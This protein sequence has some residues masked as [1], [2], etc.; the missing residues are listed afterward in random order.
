MKAISFLLVLAA[1]TVS[2]CAPTNLG[3][4]QRNGTV[5]SCHTGALPCNGEPH[6][7]PSS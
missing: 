6:Q 7:E 4:E 2:A 1:L 3:Y 5:T